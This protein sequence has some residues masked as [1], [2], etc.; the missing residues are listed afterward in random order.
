[1]VLDMEGEFYKLAKRILSSP[2]NLFKMVSMSPKT[3]RLTLM[4]AD[5]YVIVG[6]SLLRSFTKTNEKRAYIAG[7]KCGKEMLGTLIK[8]FDEEVAEL[9]PKKMFNLGLPL[10]SSTGWGKFELM[11]LDVKN[12]T[13][14]I[15]GKETIELD[16][17]KAVHHMLTCGLLASIC[18]ICL[19]TQVSG[20]AQQSSSDEVIFTFKRVLK[21]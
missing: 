21:A 14:S 11:K 16:Y 6:S 7:K 5:N 12:M 13:V 2:R 9:E 1:M 4:G 20:T 18:S 15:R 10:C 17:P 3:S 19:R 8:E